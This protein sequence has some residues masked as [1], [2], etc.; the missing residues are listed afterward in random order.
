MIKPTFIHFSKAIIASLICL[1]SIGLSNGVASAATK[2]SK[3]A[4]RTEKRTK[5]RPG[6]KA[7]AATPKPTQMKFIT[8]AALQPGD[9]IAIVTP[10]S[11]IE[12]KLVSDAKSVL[13]RQG[14]NVKVLPHVLSASGSYAGTDDERFADLKAALLNPNIK[15]IL[16]SRGGYGVVHLLDSLNTLPLRENPKW[17]IGF[18]DITAL[19]ALMYKNRIQ[20]IHG[21]MSARI[22]ETGGVD[23]DSQ[24]LFKILS[25]DSVSYK[26]DAHRYNKP[27][28][29][30]GRL[31]GGNLAVFMGLTGTPYDMTASVATTNK[32]FNDKEDIILFI[33]DVSEPIY[34]IERILYQL[35]ME[36][37][38]SHVKGLIVGQFTDYKPD[39]DYKNMDDMIALLTKDLNI[40]IA[41]NA[42]IGHVDHNIPL[43]EGR[44]TTLQVDADGATI[45]Q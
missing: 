45:T 11:S 22:S 18:S 30:R 32:K 20:S 9:T 4:L 21:P 27:G 15:A 24:N 36:G 31:V 3:P 35:R 29:A 28:T 16:C 17:I 34:K 38:L 13:E 43:V 2:Q 14:W 40:P 12:P 8:P 33:E 39:D 42:P 23:E 44:M 7:S 25:G 41:F 19:H 5:K 1:V 6:D 26:I 37:V 10:A